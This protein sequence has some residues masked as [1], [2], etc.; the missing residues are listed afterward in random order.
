MNHELF[1]YFTTDNKS[2]KKSTEI[3]LSKNNKDI[4]DRIINWCSN[5][6]CLSNISF[7]QQIYHYINDIKQIPVCKT[8]GGSVNYKRLKDGYSTYCSDKCVKS[9]NIYKEKWKNTWHE[10][11]D[12][13]VSIKKRKETNIK[14]H[15]NLDKYNEYLCEIKKKTCIS[16]YGSEY[17]FQTDEFKKNRKEKLLEIYGDEN[18]NNPYKTKTTRI[19]N[20]TQINDNLVDEFNNYKIILINRTNTIYR[21]NKEI[22]NPNNYKRC[23][24]GYHLDHKYS[25][26]QGFLN[27]IPIEIMSHPCNLE[28]IK[29]MDNLKKQDDCSITAEQLLL[30]IMNYDNELKFTHNELNEKYSDIKLISEKILEK[31]NK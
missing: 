24:K 20:G 6:Y 9:S 1:E 15:G 7:K 11:N 5:I 13:G 8:C 2:G 10:N 27:K 12:D 3:W 25:I 23:K 19:E 29:Y 21:N 31:I 26:K 16:R 22:I 17:Y 28:M 4:Y 14:K 18:F 30:N